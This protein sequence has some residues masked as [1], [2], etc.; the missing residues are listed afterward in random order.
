MDGHVFWAIGEFAREYNNAAGG[1]PGGT[2]G[3]RWGTFIGEILVPAPEPSS[4]ALLGL[5]LAAV[6]GL[7][8]KRKPL[9]G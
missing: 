2:G 3:S 4:L 9:L 8:K 7:S 5:G 1:H 6:A